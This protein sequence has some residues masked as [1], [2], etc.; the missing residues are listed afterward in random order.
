MTIQNSKCRY[1]FIAL[2]AGWMT[3]IFLMSAAPGMQSEDA[4]GRLTVFVQKAFF[5]RWESLPEAEFHN[6]LGKLHYFLRKL[7]HFAEYAMLG[8]LL[9]LVL[10]TFELRFRVRF[11]IGFFAG[12]LYAITDE[13]HQLFVPAREGAAFD[14]LVDA[15][16]VLAGCIFAFGSFAM[17]YADSQVRESGMHRES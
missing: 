7:S 6:M 17:A 14:V 1:I 13:I 8:V 9:S 2:L 4:S 16:G 11:L 15:A 10:M 5:K 12:T 3:F